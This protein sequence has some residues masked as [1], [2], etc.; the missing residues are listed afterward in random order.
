MIKIKE[1]IFR[2]DTGRTSPSQLKMFMDQVEQ[3]LP[4][5][6]AF[7]V[8]DSKKNRSLQQLKYLFGVPL[9]MLSVETGYDPKDLYRIVE[10][11]FCPIKTITIKGEE[12][13]VQDIK[14][15][16]SKE[17]GTLIEELIKWMDVE[18]GI[19]VPD[20]EQVKDPLA[21]DQYVTAYNES[22]VTR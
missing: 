16:T 11:K 10:H 6:Y 13:I 18:F 14:Q 12:F 21:A 20:K 2:D 9:K 3:L 5:E 17:M 8:L 22:W 7:Y 19:I 4:G 15:L 1:K